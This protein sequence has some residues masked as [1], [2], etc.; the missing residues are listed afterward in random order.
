M[1]VEQGDPKQSRSS[2]SS[3]QYKYG[4]HKILQGV[5][6][7]CFEDTVE[8][9]HSAGFFEWCI[10]FDRAISRSQRVNAACCTSESITRADVAD[11]EACGSSLRYSPKTSST[12]S[13]LSWGYTVI[14]HLDS[15]ISQP[16]RG[17]RSSF[18]LS[19]GRCT[20][21]TS[22]PKRSSS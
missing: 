5:R 17:I 4:F 14:F 16:T 9:R 18:T 11:L 8:L 20:T 19:N 6:H 15:F 2:L 3:S 7:A 12:K 1:K 10:K 22:R 13:S 21:F